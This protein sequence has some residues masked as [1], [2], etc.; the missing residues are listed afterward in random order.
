MVEAGVGDRGHVL[1]SK[2]DKATVTVYFN[3]LPK[4]DEFPPPTRVDHIFKWATGNK[5]FDLSPA[6]RAEHVLVLLG[7]LDKP[8]DDIHIGSLTGD[9]GHVEFELISRERWQG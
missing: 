5:G 3:N 9:A 7:T 2:R 1:V 8:D 4:S 6:D